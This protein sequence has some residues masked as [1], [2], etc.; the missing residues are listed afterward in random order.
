MGFFKREEFIPNLDKYNV[1]DIPSLRSGLLG[2]EKETLA[3]QSSFT[4]LY[5]VQLH[6][7]SHS[8]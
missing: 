7:F 6:P 4:E 8:S 2:W 5:K 3:N 1:Y